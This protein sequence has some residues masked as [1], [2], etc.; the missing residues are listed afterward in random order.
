MISAFGI[1]HT[2]IAK[3]LNPLAALKAVKTAKQSRSTAHAVM[4]DTP[5]GGANPFGASP[6]KPKL[7]SLGTGLTPR[8]AA[9]GMKKLSYRTGQNSIATKDSR[10]R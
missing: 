9:P 6:A 5:W 10:Y 7:A 4:R 3:G 2:Q 8:P 1:E